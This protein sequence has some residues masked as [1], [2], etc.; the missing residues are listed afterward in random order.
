MRRWK[1]CSI[2]ILA[3]AFGA[4]GCGGGASSTSITL[5]INPTAASVVTNTSQS[6]VSVVGGSTNT[7]V[8]WTLTCPTG[9]T[10]PACGTINANGLYTAPATVPTVT[11]NGT[12]TIT[13]TATITATAQ[14]DSTKT[15]TATVT[16]ISGIR[17]TITPTAATV[18][19]GETFPFTATVV[20]PGCNQSIVGNHCLEVTWTLSTTSGVGSIDA[21]GLYTAP[22]TAPS[23]STVAITATSV[24][25]TSITAI[26]TVTVVTA[27][28]PTLTSVSPK[29]V[30][31]GSLFQDIYITGTNFIST[32]NVF[33]NG[34][35]IAATSAAGFSSSVIRARIPA[36]LMAVPPPSGILQ[37]TVSRQTGTPQNCAPDVTQ[38][39]IVVS[40]VRPAI[41]GPSPDSISQTPQ[42]C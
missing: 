31:L 10:A 11:T 38:C 28:D 4:L 24:S 6:F 18:G 15:A 36:T 13:P 14:A 20:N 12:V 37:V 9:V 17:I 23:P 25:D 34:T 41:A 29:T 35:L 21:N 40:G 16:I 27:V 5:T 1:F 7:A 3:L 32:N 2:L 33:V 22:A 26:A 39:Q 30:G 19:T 8:T 42:E